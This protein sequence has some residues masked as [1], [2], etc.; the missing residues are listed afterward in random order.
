[1]IE[2]EKKSIKPLDVNSSDYNGSHPLNLLDHDGESFLEAA[3]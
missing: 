2:R 3:P 1:M